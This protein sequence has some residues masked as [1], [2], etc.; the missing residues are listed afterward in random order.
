MTHHAPH[1]DCPAR[2]P[3]HAAVAPA[4]PRWPLRAA[5]R[6]VIAAGSCVAGLCLVIGLIAVVTSAAAPRRPP[7]NVT[8]Q[9]NSEPPDQPGLQGLASAGP[10]TV[11]FTTQPGSSWRLTWEFRCPRR[12]GRRYFAIRA[13]SDGLQLARSGR[14]GQGITRAYRSA[15]QHLLAVQSGCGW[16]VRVLQNR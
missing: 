4:A 1:Q 15:G 8:A 9:A 14:H 7:A 10:A 12:G 13:S 3:R 11:R 6:L 5:L 2:F 16:R